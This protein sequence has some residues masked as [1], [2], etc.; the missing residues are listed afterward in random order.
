[1]D[2]TQRGVA[3]GMA[4]AGI[5]AIIGLVV[6]GRLTPSVLGQDLA[7]QDRLFIGFFAALA[8]IFSLI[9]SVA[10][11]ARH[12]FFTPEDIDGSG[13]V[14]GTD[15][16]NRLQAMLQNTLEQAVLVISVYFGC[17][18]VFPTAY[19][20]AVVAGG[21]M[22][23]IGRIAFYVGYKHGA[24]SRAFGFAF[25]FYP[26]VFLVIGALFFIIVHHK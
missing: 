9:F 19:L 13:L 23:L 18:I 7:L 3:R 6:C 1:M 4:V 8:P 16:A 14:P 10:R 20:G 11:L 25:T 5:L 15:T 2:A 24:V 21:A 17:V 12:R 26:T 22:F